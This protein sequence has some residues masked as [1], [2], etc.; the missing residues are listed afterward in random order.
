MS[1]SVAVAIALG[2]TATVWLIVAKTKS[3]PLYSSNGFHMVSM[4]QLPMFRNKSLSN[5]TWELGAMRTGRLLR[6]HMRRS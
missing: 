5:A 3:V 4:N 2:C 1:W 6:R